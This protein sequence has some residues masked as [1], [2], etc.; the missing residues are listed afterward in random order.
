MA[1]VERLGSGA[2]PDMLLDELR[3]HASQRVVE[4]RG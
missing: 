3:R 2:E 1:A 4:L